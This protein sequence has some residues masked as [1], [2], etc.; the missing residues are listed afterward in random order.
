MSEV[1]SLL[2]IASQWLLAL[3]LTIVLTLFFLSIAGAQITSEG[4][5]QRILRRAIA[6]MTEIDADLPRIEAGLHKAAAEGQGETVRV[7]DFPIPVDI[8]REE[9]GTIDGARLRD[10]IL[11]ESARRLYDDGMSVWAAADPNARQSI[12]RVSTAGI[13]EQGLG[14]VR[15]SRHTAFIVATVLLGLISAALTAILAISIR[16]Y[17]VRLLAV[18]GVVLV[19]A[20]PL[21][22]GAVAIRFG[23][24]TGETEADPFV[25]GLLELGVDAMWIPIRDY[26]VLSM[27][28]FALVAVAASCLWWQARERQV[29]RIDAG[30]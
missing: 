12:E 20:L 1:S 2:R 17:Y 21:L 23:F 16:S 4:T 24:K 5:G 8:T 6:V 3:V 7:P 30:V 25:K 29:S 28:G 11:E 22:A 13:I 10:R 27:L 18:G 26:L 19:A 14:Q 9:A 15:G